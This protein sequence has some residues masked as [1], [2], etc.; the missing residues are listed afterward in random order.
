MW[1][2]LH[3]RKPFYSREPELHCFHAAAPSELADHNSAL[4]KAK[5]LLQHLQGLG[6]PVEMGKGDAGGVVN[7]H[8]LFWGREE[9]LWAWVPLCAGSQSCPGPSLAP[10]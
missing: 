4:R 2:S 7:A 3:G 9:P 6:G 8:P 10:W 1:T 5:V